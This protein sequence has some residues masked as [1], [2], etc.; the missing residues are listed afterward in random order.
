MA[1]IRY[2]IKSAELKPAMIKL[3]I[4]SQKELCARSGVSL[5]SIKRLFSETNKPH[6]LKTAQAVADSLGFDVNE[7]FTVQEVSKT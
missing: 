1:K 4:R 3:G 7:L 2:F 5:R 6:T